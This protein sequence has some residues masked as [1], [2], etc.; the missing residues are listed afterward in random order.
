VTDDFGF[1]SPQGQIYF[2]RNDRPA[3]RPYLPPSQS[4]SVGLKR[5]VREADKLLV[6]SVDVKY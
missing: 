5:P 3:V 4:I 6:S 1:D 2:F